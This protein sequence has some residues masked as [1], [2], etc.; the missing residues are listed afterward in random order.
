M[1]SLRDLLHFGTGSLC[2]NTRKL[3][4]FFLSIQTTREWQA[5]KWNVRFFLLDYPNC[6]REFFVI[7]INFDTVKG[8][9][10]AYGQKRMEVEEECVQSLKTFRELK[11]SNFDVQNK[12]RYK[13]IMMENLRLICQDF[14]RAMEY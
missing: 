10:E 6:Q 12:Q 9:G 11:K 8:H 13:K 14:Q 7:S 3:S 4:N 1:V 5:S 2:L